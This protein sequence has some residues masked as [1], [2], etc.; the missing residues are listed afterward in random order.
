MNTE[1]WAFPWVLRA[2]LPL[3]RL[4][5]K[6]IK[7]S[8][9]VFISCYFSNVVVGGVDQAE[10]VPFAMLFM[11]P[12]MIDAFTQVELDAFTRH[13]SY[14]VFGVNSVGI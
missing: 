1:N 4:T 12:S 14:S 3:E 6:T 7:R 9:L 13:N 11:M 10:A 8:V 2:L 5:G